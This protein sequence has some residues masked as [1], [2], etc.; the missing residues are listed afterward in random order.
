MRLVSATLVGAVAAALSFGVHATVIYASDAPFIPFSA[1][2]YFG[3]GPITV[4]P[5]ITW[6]SSNT[7]IQGG[8]VYGYNA[9]YEFGSNGTSTAT[10]TGLNDSSDAYSVVD[11]MTFSFATPVSSVGAVLNWTPNVLPVTIAVYDSGDDL[12]DSLTLSSGDDNLVTPSSFYGF[13]EST[14]DISSFVLTDGYVATLYGLDGIG[15]SISP[16]PEPSA[17]MLMLAGIGGLGAVLRGERRRRATSLT[18]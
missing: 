6:T 17:W 9:G 13:L 3:G 15:S 11:S 10:L 5:G 16:A 12:L 8:A 1:V 7:T 4:T 14:A 2:N 18:A